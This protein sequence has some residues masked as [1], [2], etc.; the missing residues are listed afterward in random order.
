MCGIC[1]ILDTKNNRNLEPEVHSMMAQLVH[2]GPDDSGVFIHQNNRGGEAAVGFGHRRLSIID[3]SAAAHQPMEGRSRD[4]AVVLNG[5]IYNFRERRSECSDYPFRSNSDTEIIL[6]LY[7]KYGESF[8]EKLEGMFAL[9]L[10]DGKKGRLL[11]A[12]DRAGKKPLYYSQGQGGF[13]AFA[14]EIK[15]LLVLP[16]A[17]TSIHPDA[18]L[19]YL[20]FGYVPSPCTFYRRI[21]KL[22][23]GTLMVVD[24]SGAVSSRTFWNYPLPAGEVAGRGREQD[25][26]ATLRSLMTKA[27]SRRLVSDVPLGAFL[28]GGIDSSIIVGTMCRLSKEPVKTFSIGFE[29]DASFDETGYARMVARHFGTSHTEFRVRPNAIELIEK[30]VWHYDEP[31]GDSSAIPTHIVSKL[32]REHVTV[33][34]SGDGGDEVF[35]GYERFAA[36]LWT[37][38]FPGALFAAGRG[39]VSLLPAPVHPKSIRRRV[40]RFF[41]KSTLPFLDR[42]LEWNSFFSRED[43]AQMLP[44]AVPGNIAASFEECLHKSRDC[45]ILKR[46]LYLNYRTYLLDD[47]LVKT[48]RMSMANGLEV[49]CPFLDTD[50]VAWSATL[51]DRLKIRGRQLKYLLRRSYRD[52]LPPDIL[53]RGKMGFGIPLGHWMRNDLREYSRDLLLGPSARIRAILEISRVEALLH[54]HQQQLQDHGQKIWSLLTLEIWLRNHP[55]ARENPASVIPP[56]PSFPSITHQGDSSYDR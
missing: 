4:T 14:S 19:L 55:A 26:S 41:A 15:A 43:L 29:G 33:A 17:D 30:L 6:A 48:D 36:A 13:F 42:Y 39:L 53:S 9:A 54:E 28:S 16:E 44:D 7:E 50:L 38:R 2:R 35:A 20:T 8:A 1:G 27:V 5:E 37:E 3:L 21:H 46:L 52:L 11:L 47:L 56:Q 51:P 34:L 22:E 10:W 40:K 24:S 45:S 31:F 23:P 49:R 12:R 18:L 32:A 25:Y